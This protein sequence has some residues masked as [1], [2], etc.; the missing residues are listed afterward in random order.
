[1]MMLLMM[2]MMMMLGVVSGM[3]SPEAWEG[4]LA[5]DVGASTGPTLAEATAAMDHRK[6]QISFEASLETVEAGTYDELKTVITNAM[7]PTTV[8]VMNDI[9]FPGP[10]EIQEEQTIFLVAGNASTFDASG[11]NHFVIYGKASMEGLTF[12]NGFALNG[13]SILVDDGGSLLVRNSTFVNNNA[14]DLPTSYPTSSPT[15]TLSPTNFPPSPAPTT[16]PTFAPTT[17]RAPTMAPSVTSGATT[18][19]DVI[20][21]EPPRPYPGTGDGGA[22]AALNGSTL[23]IYDSYFASNVAFRMG[24]AVVAEDEA[25]LTLQGSFFEDNECLGL[26]L[27]GDGFGAGGGAVSVIDN[28]FVDISESVFRRN[29]AKTAGGAVYS[30]ANHALTLTKNR[31]EENGLHPEYIPYYANLHGGAVCSTNTAIFTSKDSIY[32]NNRWMSPIFYSFQYGGAVQVINAEVVVSENDSFSKNGITDVDGQSFFVETTGFVHIQGGG[33]TVTIQQLVQC[34]VTITNT[35]FRGNA[36]EHGGGLMLFDSYS[37]PSGP[38]VGRVSNCEFTD[39]IGIS[40]GA[41][42]FTSGSLIDMVLTDTSF[43]GGSAGFGGAVGTIGVVTPGLTFQNVLMD[44]NKAH[45]GGAFF[46]AMSGGAVT[47][48][49]SILSN[50]AADIVEEHFH[51]GSI[52]SGGAVRFLALQIQGVIPPP[53]STVHVFQNT[54]VL[55][56][57]ALDNGGAIAIQRHDEE[58]LSLFPA[59]PELSYSVALDAGSVVTGNVAKNAGGILIKSL[60]PVQ[61]TLVLNDT[62]LQD[63]TPDD[64]F[65]NE[66]G[67]VVGSVTGNPVLGGNLDNFALL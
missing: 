45:W 53:N 25:S 7:V 15:I 37:F 4:T 13:G 32:E 49:D 55:N 31:F 44:N 54:S 65:S 20:E 16:P 56:N 61:H 34:N 67:L 27:P 19:P 63:N 66:S 33:M 28:S 5:F 1:M 22:I 41:G 42:F 48:Q 29:R 46:G 50:N 36:A 62:L 9:V 2:M 3:Q 12:T 14:G 59:L 47:F 24:G 17:T 64:I 21:N 18:D 23:E 11:T 40:A 10:V 58:W 8:V 52:P 43:I 60:S 30:L 39:N 6:L 26:G 57:T 38:I 35:T 51:N